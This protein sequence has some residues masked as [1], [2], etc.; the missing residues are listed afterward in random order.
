MVKAVEKATLVVKGRRFEDWESVTVVHALSDVQNP[1]FTFRFTASEATPPKKTN[2]I[3]LQIKPGDECQ[4]YLA[5]I[6]AFTG[7]VHTRQVFYNASRHYI[8]IQ[9]AYS[10]AALNVNSTV[11]KTME[12]KKVTGEQIIRGLIKPYGSIINLKILGGALPTH[13]FRRCSVPHGVSTFDL[14]DL[15]MRSL[16]RFP[17]TSN[18]QGDLVVLAGQQGGSGD[19]FIEGKNILEGREIIYDSASAGAGSNAT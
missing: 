14:I 2:L 16:G 10:G 12:M 6:L 18:P 8:E 17:I 19:T 15:C 5:G 9:G 4:I 3:A 1:P 7:Y 13:K 11:T